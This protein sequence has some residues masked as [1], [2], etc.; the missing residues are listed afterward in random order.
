MGIKLMPNIPTSN[1][2]PGD[3]RDPSTG[4]FMTFPD[5]GQGW[6]AL[7]NDLQNK[8][9]GKTRTGLNGNSTLMDFAA[10]YA[11]DND[12]NNSGNYA[13]NLANS[14]KVRPDTKLSDLLPR[15]PDWANAVAQHEGYHG[16]F[17]PSSQP[18]DIKPNPDTAGGAYQPNPTY[19]TPV[20]TGQLTTPPKSTIGQT[21]GNAVNATA[22]ALGIQKAGQGMATAV[23]E[24]TGG[25]N[26]EGDAQGQA[27]Q[28]LSA[29]MAKYP[30]G[31]P[32]REAAIAQYQQLYQGGVPTEA[33]I[34]PGT[35]LSN[36]EV[37]GSFGNVGLLALSGAEAPGAEAAT[38]VMSKGVPLATS[39][40]GKTALGAGLGYGFDVAGRANAN[41]QGNIY[42]PGMGTLVG[43]ALPGLLQAGG[44]TAGKLL[45]GT[46]SILGGSAPALQRALDNPDAIFTAAKQ[47]ADTPEKTQTLI[48][49]AKDALNSFLRDRSQQFGDSLSS[50]TASS[51]IDKQTVLDSFAKQVGN[52]GGQITDNGLEFGD[53][54]LTSTEQKS[55]SDV[56]D[57]VKSW[58]NVT[59]QGM[60]TLRQRLGAEMDN[61]KLANNGAENVVLGNV[62]TDLTNLMS[63]KIPG[64][65][66]MLSDYGTQTQTARDLANDLSMG[67][68]AKSSTQLNQ[69]MKI[70]KKDPSVTANLV[71]VMGQDG[72]NKFL[73][74][75][76][77]SILSKWLPQGRFSQ[78][79]DTLLEAGIGGL[80]KLV[81]APQTLP[82]MA[83]TAAMSSP[84]LSGLAA[85]GIGKFT[86]AAGGGLL[87]GLLTQQ[88]AKLNK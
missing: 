19:A 68:K 5:E 64:Y 60:D 6:A 23:R 18:S 9:Q 86:Q 38:G 20:P 32:A 7:L 44:Y 26:E 84:R 74:D 40:L 57:T 75:V 81:N 8:A 37:L 87:R 15:L 54:K 4:K 70:F 12:G 34:D 1:N 47:F 80:G 35:A 22:G 83:G 63:S 52:F 31:S 11:P 27:L 67:G 61:F 2:N 88:A 30:V 41:Q 17:L 56:Y 25:G 28:Q 69:I 46:A 10:T 82:V 13:A 55:L 39:L 51:P 59:P 45:K 49:T 24:F 53:T 58:K 66:Q 72:A 65:S 43:G 48:S 36:K 14:L 29:I 77:G 50:M 79:L 76:S 62:K 85:M 3:L 33:E 78:G 16:T 71:K 21:A 73:D 42:K